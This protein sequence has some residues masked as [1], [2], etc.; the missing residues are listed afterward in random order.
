M[1]FIRAPFFQIVI[2]SVLAVALGACGPEKGGEGDDIP[3]DPDGGGGGDTAN[4]NC[5][6]PVPEVC[7]NGQ[8]DDCD[9]IGDCDDSDCSS[10]PS[11]ANANCGILETPSASLSLPDGDCPKD[12][13][14][15]CDGFESDLVFTGFSAGQQ[16][17]DITKLLGICVNMEHSWMRDLV[18]YAECPSGTR[19]MLSDF[20]GHMGGQV[21]LGEPNDDDEFG[22]P[23]PGVGWDYC[24]TPTATRMPWIP[25]ANANPAVGTLPAGDYQSSQPLNAFVGCPLNGNWTLRVEDRWGIDNGFIFSWTVRFDASIV[26]DCENWPG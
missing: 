26:E 1:K 20:E 15:P 7:N 24:W 25:Y 17:T 18:I 14:Q 11:C 12:E 10:D 8:D 23:V 21:F 22:D 16:L 3:G 5:T 19:V 6:N 13:T 2:T 4:P 9:N